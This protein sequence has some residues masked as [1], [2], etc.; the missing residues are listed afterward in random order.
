MISWLKAH[1]DDAV[2]GTAGVGSTAHIGAIRFQQLTGTTFR[3][4]PYGGLGPAMQELIAGRIDIVF[5]LAGNTTA[6]VESGT[7]KALAVTAKSRL[8]DAPDI[9]TVAEAGLSEFQFINW[10]A[11]F[12][13]RGTPDV[14]LKRLNDAIVR[15]LTDAPTVKR[16][17]AIGQQLPARD[18][19]TPQALA[20]YQRNEIDTWWPVI[21]STSVHQ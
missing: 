7:I 2:A 21:K 16:L 12:A 10:H 13:P 20:E 18:Q 19:L 11:I 15:A 9:P 4:V 1:P 17:S 8:V 6:H 5:G 14:V 3:F